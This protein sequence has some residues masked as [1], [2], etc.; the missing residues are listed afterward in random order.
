MAASVAEQRLESL[1]ASLDAFTRHC[2]DGFF[3][4][5]CLVR[6]EPLAVGGLQAVGAE[7]GPLVI[8]RPFRRSGR[9][10][11]ARLRMA[12]GERKEYRRALGPRY[13]VDDQRGHHTVGIQPQVRRAFLFSVGEID[14]FQRMRQL[15][16]DEHPVHRE[17]GGAGRVIQ[18]VHGASDSVRSP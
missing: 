6:I 2:F 17:A 7:K 5:G 4:A 18:L 14:Q 9:R 15:Q 16:L 1:P 12:V 10:R 13:A 8:F 11:K 3:R